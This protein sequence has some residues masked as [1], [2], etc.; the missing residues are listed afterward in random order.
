GIDIGLLKNRLMVTAEYY[1][2]KTEDVILNKEVAY[3]YGVNS[4]P[5]NGGNL[6]NKG[7]ELSIAMTPVRTRDF[8]W[9]LSFNTSK[10]Y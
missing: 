5:I 1:H 4:M 7:W 6:Y 3:E 2:K 9:T 10:N 8:L